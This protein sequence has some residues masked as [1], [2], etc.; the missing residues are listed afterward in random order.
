MQTYIKLTPHFLE[1][2]QKILD[3]FTKIL[4][5]FI[6]KNVI[7]FKTILV[8]SQTDDVYSAKILILF[9][10]LFFNNVFCQKNV[11]SITFFHQQIF[12]HTLSGRNFPMHMWM[13]LMTAAPQV[14][15]KQLDLFSGNGFAREG[16]SDWL[17]LGWIACSC[18]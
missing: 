8:F 9:L 5:L 6:K 12:N 2:L 1:H 15:A 14:T 11:W 7:L 4:D 17:T 16:P 13:N 10:F 18:K 3:L